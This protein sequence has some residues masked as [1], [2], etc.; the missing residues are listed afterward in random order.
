MNYGII[1]LLPALLVI[2]VAIKSKRTT[3]ALLMGCVSS[4]LI[5]A[6][7]NKKNPITLMVDSFFEVITDYD[8]VWLLIVC[9]LF[10]SL[11]AVINAAKGTHAI[12]NFLGKI[13]KTGKSTLL[14][15]WLLGI[16]IFV[17]DYMNI[18][19]I[20]ACTKRLSDLRRVP[21]EALAYVI[22]STGAPVCVLLPFSTWAIFFAGIFYEQKEVVELGYGSAMS[23]YIHSIP[24][25]FYAMVAIVVVP[26]FILGVMPKMGAMKKAYQRVETTGRV[27]SE[28][29]GKL[30]KKDDNDTSG[31]A[32]II[33]FLIPIATMIIIQLVVGD[34]F[35]AIIS[36]I[37]SAAIIYVPRKKVKTNEF[38][39]LWIQG[40]ADSIPAL[41]IIVAALWMRQASADLNLPQYIIG[42]VEPIV[43]PH[44]YPMIAFMVVAVLGFIT[45]S[46]WGIPAV[47]APIII[48]LGAA[49][50]ANLLTVMAAIVCGGTF[51]SHACFYS[52]ATVITSASCG[53]ENMEHV[54]SQLP[55]TIVSAVVA[56]LLFLISGYLF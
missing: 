32:K 13:C 46:N 31:D 3:E 36:A 52:D 34:M 35:I 29:S 41:A 50:G 7:I 33:D 45:G 38:C 4:Y 28:N 37:I 49:C 2:I 6:V 48:P 39:D 16:I 26:L 8:T 24:Y 27:Y 44:I 42:L 51:C 12:A 56:S 47:C 9:G 14:T 23:T 11:I 10:G 18:M 1:T 25:M 30:N 53:I 19:T 20:S 17:D 15:S 55:Y 40:F 54:Y 22:D 43:T 5:I 21:R